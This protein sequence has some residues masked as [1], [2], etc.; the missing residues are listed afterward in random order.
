LVFAAVSFSHIEYTD[1]ETSQFE[2][3]VRQQI[4]IFPTSLLY[5]I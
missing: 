2:T 3:N 1:P 4:G 5:I